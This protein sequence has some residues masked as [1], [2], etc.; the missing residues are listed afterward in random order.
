MTAINIFLQGGLGNQLFQYAL[1]KSLQ[2]RGHDITFNRGTLVDNKTPQVPVLIKPEVYGPGSPGYL[3]SGGVEYGLDGLRT[4]VKFGPPVGIQY[5]EGPLTFRSE[6]FGFTVPTTLIGFWQTE[7]YFEN[8]ADILRAEF[9]PLLDPSAEIANLA[10]R[11]SNT[12]SVA[13]HVRRGE[14]VRCSDIVKAH[15]AISRSYYEKSI[16]LILSS[17]PNAQFFVFSDEPV[18]CEQNLPVGEIVSTNSRFWDLWLMSKCRHAII[19]NSSFSWWSA[20]LGNNKSDRMVVTPDRW[21]LVD[22]IDSKDIVP[23]GW[24]RLS[25]AYE[26]SI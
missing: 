3:V 11:L 14:R 2:A 12:N 5:I 16:Q 21:T 13:L 19:P 24:I 1:G 18:W 20:W 17:H 6:V 15:G 9:V 10:G 8:V 22:S 23:S 7:K 4:N 25:G 26:E